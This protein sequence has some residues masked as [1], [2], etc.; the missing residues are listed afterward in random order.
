[1]RCFSLSLSL[2]VSQRCF[3]FA[4]A[5]LCVISLVQWYL[6]F[7]Y[8]NPEQCIKPTYNKYLFLLI[9]TTAHTYTDT[10]TLY[11]SIFLLSKKIEVNPEGQKAFHSNAQRNRKKKRNPAEGMTERE[12][13]RGKRENHWS[14]RICFLYR[15][16]PEMLYSVRAFDVGLGCVCR[17][18]CVSVGVC[19]YW[20]V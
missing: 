17:C 4:G 15:N 18:G 5:S 16:T 6:Y 7:W 12:R 14:W 8:L 2:D 13:I 20:Y 10:Y 11:L 19:A 9:P 1:M 3:F